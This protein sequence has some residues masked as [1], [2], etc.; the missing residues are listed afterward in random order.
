MGLHIHHGS[1]LCELTEALADLLATPLADPFTTEVIAVPT[2]G[3]RDWL[4]QQLALRLG[5]T[6]RADGVSANIDM[7]FP[8]RFIARALGQTDAADDPWDIDHL[9]WA[10]LNALHITSIEVPGNTRSSGQRPGEFS[11]RYATARRIA[12]LFDRYANHRPQML[13]QWHLGHD[14]DGTLDE[15]LAVV[16]I[17]ADQQWQ[18]ALWREARKLIGVPSRAELMPVL[19][20][21]LAQGGARDNLPERVALFGVSAIAPAQLN[22]L[23]ALAQHREVH[24]F[25]VHPSPVAWQG[26]RQ[27]L[28]GQLILRSVCDPTAR[29]RHPLLRS[30]ARPPMEATA[31]V[32][33][34]LAQQ[35]QYEHP[36]HQYQADNAPTLLRQLQSDIAADREPIGARPR[37]IDPSVQVHACH[38]TTRQLEV[39]RDAL[40]HLFA[41][42]A[43]LAAHEVVIVCPDLARFAP[44]INSVFRRGSF[45]VPVQISDLSLGTDNPVA[46]A[47][48]ALLDLVGGRCTAAELLGLCSLA[49]VQ[50]CIGLTGDDLARIDQWITDLSTTWGLDAEHRSTWVPA[51]IT[52]G[53]WEASLDRLLLGAAMPAPAPRV[54]VG[55]IVPF[56]DVDADG[57]RTA[58][59]LAEVVARLR[60]ARAAMLGEHTIHEWADAL[61]NLVGALCATHPDDAWQLAQ[62]IDTIAQLREHSLVAG[63][64]CSV[65]L[66]L[67]DI[68]VLLNG[69]L[70]E[71][72]GRLNLRSGS[73]TVTAMVP[74]RNIPARVVCV[75]GLDEVSLR[76]S[77]SDGDDLLGVH[78]CVGERDQR[79]EGRHLLL[80]AL[81]TAGD[82]LIITCDGS[83]ITTNRQLP[84]PVQLI[85]LLDVVAATIAPSLAVNTEGGR[86]ADP[87]QIVV[88]HHPRQAYDE[89]NFVTEP[90]LVAGANQPFGFDNAMLAAALKRRASLPTHADDDLSPFSTVLEPLVPDTVTLQQLTESCTR[91]ARTFLID[92]LDVRLP[93]EPEPMSSDIPLG[94]S[95]LEFS[96][97]GRSLLDQYR[98]AASPEQ[99]YEWRQAQ[100]LGGT[101]PP[102]ELAHTS[103]TQ[104]EQDV[105]KVVEALPELAAL[106]TNTTNEHLDIVLVGPGP[107]HN[108]V[109]LIDTL[110]TIAGDTLIR[111]HY[112]RPSSRFALGAALSLAAA[113]VAQPDR[114]W[115]AI[116]VT[117][118][119][120]TARPKPV[121]LR[122]LAGEGRRGAAQQFLE[123]ALR[124]RLLALREPIP[125]FERSS[126][127]LFSTGSFNETSYS[128]DL[129]DAP[130]GFLWGHNTA[131]DVLAGATGARA[132]ALAHSLWG[133]YH[134]FVSPPSQ[135]LSAPP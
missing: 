95:P 40:G 127:V 34:L 58:G 122:P 47:L 52:E 73:V 125:L 106:I 53:T 7:L 39:L 91:P 6:G 134:A 44:L 21:N 51:H 3:V 30:W 103:L 49:P 59:L 104:V 13:H 25:L 33:M 37:V 28:A 80:D 26:C 67:S 9:T 131:E 65:P 130:T 124:L 17:P 78:P 60:I 88:T 48:C 117:R 97:I 100:Q 110:A 115:Q 4:Q 126:E 121:H 64:E 10:V 132:S 12:D 112:N 18:P 79:V 68:R 89:R 82:Q 35:H 66:S 102:R 70:T 15:H 11:I 16:P 5:A 46:T 90:S 120:D 93:R 83:D 36:P 108:E 14:G 24:I 20:Q 1:H 8:G 107:E 76:S 133:A 85:E 31:L 114:D 123:V 128:D 55:N 22:V 41:A 71:Q 2:A 72:H 135:Q 111:V 19:L 119:K 87:D 50:R 61:T 105:A 29:V 99:I 43:S 116:V 113:V 69:V 98:S 38:G 57:F 81:M 84:L 42:D 94:I 86:E 75:L 92:R 63:A 23:R 77:G 74:V 32:G 101:L 27:L 54:G 129:K 56:D 45:P 109:R 118:G 62:V 96:R